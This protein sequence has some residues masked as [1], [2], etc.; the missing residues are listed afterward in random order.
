MHDDGDEEDMEE[1]E[2]EK[3]VRY[4]DEG[5]EDQPDSDKDEEVRVT[6]V[7]GGLPNTL[8]WTF[9]GVFSSF[10]LFFFSFLFPS[11]FSVLFSFLFSFFF[12]FSLSFLFFPGHH[13]HF[14]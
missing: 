3:A 4:Y 5:I 12:F 13:H 1:H 9:F 7:T 11:W 14:V 2:V 10:F 6:A 8:E